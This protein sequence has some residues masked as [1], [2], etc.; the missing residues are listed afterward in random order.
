MSPAAAPR[1]TV[2]TVESATLARYG[3]AF[4]PCKPG[5]SEAERRSACLMIS[6]MAGEPA[7]TAPSMRSSSP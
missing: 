4:A 1:I 2:Q 5:V 7:R 6:C 3:T